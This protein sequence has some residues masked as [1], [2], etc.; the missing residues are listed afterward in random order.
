VPS[1]GAARSVCVIEAGRTHYEVLGVPPGAP[2]EAIREAYRRLAR[3]HH[4][5]RAASGD[6]EMSAIN[7]AYRVLEDPARRAVYDAGLR[8]RSAAG[9]ARGPAA[10]VRDWT[11]DDPAPPSYDLPP[12]PYSPARVP[13]RT[14]LAAGALAIVGVVVLAQ[15]TEP[16]EPPPPDGILH[17][18]DCVALLANTDA[19]EVECS[20]GQGDL[21]VRAFVGFDETCPGLTE[22]HRDRQ[23]LGVACIDVQ[24]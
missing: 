14:L 9:P 15:F 8:G 4:P 17:V 22:P 21:V 1:A 5:D 10:P 2:P 19:R 7:E 13:W 12:R 16:G 23:G 18:G 6:R 24:P 20:G 11:D 3:E